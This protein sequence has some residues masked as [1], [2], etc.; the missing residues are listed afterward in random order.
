MP[1]DS[2]FEGRIRHIESRPSFTPY[3]ALAEEDRQR[4]TYVTQIDMLSEDA[5]ELPVGIPVQVAL[6]D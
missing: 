4:L 3:Y 2:P 6:R 5:S 1:S